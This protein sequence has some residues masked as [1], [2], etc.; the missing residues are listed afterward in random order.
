MLNAKPIKI[1]SVWYNCFP[2]QT[3]TLLLSSM[4]CH[5]YKIVLPTGLKPLFSPSNVD[6]AA[7]PHFAKGQLLYS[8]KV[9]QMNLLPKTRSR[10]VHVCT[11]E[12][13][14]GAGD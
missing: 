9:L 5:Q 10:C 8:T 2:N 12:V 6:L 14:W 13:V 3:S 11:Y 7:S 1:L 4:N